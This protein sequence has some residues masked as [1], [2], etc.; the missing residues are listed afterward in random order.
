[1]TATDPAKPL[2]APVRFFLHN[3]FNPDKVVVVPK[4]GR[5]EL[6]LCV[7][8]AFTVGAITDGGQTKLELDLAKLPGAPAKF[9]ER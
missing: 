4:Q 7:W 6:S 5:A 2:T 8:G 3:T 1:M 9:R